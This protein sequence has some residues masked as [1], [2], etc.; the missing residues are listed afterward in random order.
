MDIYAWE[1]LFR[2]IQHNQECDL[3]FVSSAFINSLLKW[4]LKVRQTIVLVAPEI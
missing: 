1:I 4:N 3:V 2:V